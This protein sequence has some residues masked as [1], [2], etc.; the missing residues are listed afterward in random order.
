MYVFHI[1]LTNIT[2]ASPISQQNAVYGFNRD[3][4]CSLYLKVLVN[5]CP[6]KNEVP[7]IF[8]KYL[9]IFTTWKN[10]SKHDIFSLILHEPVPCYTNN[11]RRRCA[12]FLRLLLNWFINIFQAW[13][14]FDFLKCLQNIFC[15]DRTQNL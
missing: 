9:S 2:K 6:W 10:S 15:S 14:S 3:C 1:E 12:N 4:Y 11:F 5:F 13:F 7:N 8:N